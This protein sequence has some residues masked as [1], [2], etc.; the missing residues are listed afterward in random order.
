MYDCYFA[1]PGEREAKLGKLHWLT[2][3]LLHS[4]QVSFFLKNRNPYQTVKIC[5]EKPCIYT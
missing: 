2:G 5:G 3:G 4:I 1:M